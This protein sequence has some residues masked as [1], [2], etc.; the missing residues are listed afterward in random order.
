VYNTSA[1]Q[2]TVKLPP[3]S[4]EIKEK[5]SLMADPSRWLAM[6]PAEQREV[7]TQHQQ[8]GG[9]LRNFLIFAHV[10]EKRERRTGRQTDRQKRGGEREGEHYQQTGGQLHTFSSLHR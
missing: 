2:Q 4:Q 8:T 3:S 5:D 9:Q 10:R 1:V 7:E 6:P